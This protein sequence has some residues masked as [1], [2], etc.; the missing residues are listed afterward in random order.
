MVW[1]AEFAGVEVDGGQSRSR[2]LGL[3]AGATTCWERIDVAGE[4]V[5][6]ASGLLF[7]GV[8]VVAWST[9]PGCVT[10]VAVGPQTGSCAVEERW[11][12]VTVPFLHGIGGLSQ[13]GPAALI[14]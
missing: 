7:A 10:V 3:F 4:G 12:A 8:F 11:E 13:S 9:G 14:G 6:S 5:F 2:L 1:F